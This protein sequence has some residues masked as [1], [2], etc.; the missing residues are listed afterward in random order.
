[1]KKHMIPPYI[2]G[3]AG[4]LLLV[5]LAVSFF[6]VALNNIHGAQYMPLNFFTLLA[7]GVTQ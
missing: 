7:E 6:D 3:A 2:A 5:W 4:V 1:M